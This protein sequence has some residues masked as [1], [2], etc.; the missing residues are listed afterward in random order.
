M[1]KQEKIIVSAYTGCLMCDFLDV[2]NYIYDVC[3][4]TGNRIERCPELSVA[5][6]QFVCA[7]LARTRDT[8]KKAV[9]PDFRA[10]CD[11]AENSEKEAADEWNNRAV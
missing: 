9:E 2:Y 8:V 4:K 5:N 7:W 6:D 10:L 1:T 3:N 11:D